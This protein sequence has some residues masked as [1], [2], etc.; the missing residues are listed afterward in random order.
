MILHPKLNLVTLLI[1]RVPWA[2][3]MP[4]SRMVSLITTMN[5]GERSR[6]V[7]EKRPGGSY[8]SLELRREELDT[9]VDSDNSGM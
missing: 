5:K 1:Q 8:M 2:P 9:S 6:C 3:R 4:G 7:Q